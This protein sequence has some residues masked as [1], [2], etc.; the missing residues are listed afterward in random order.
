[1]CHL[2]GLTPASRPR[3]A[4]IPAP[5]SQRP[6]ARIVGLG[7]QS[8]SNWPSSDAPERVLGEPVVVRFGLELFVGST[9]SP[10]SANEFCIT[11]PRSPSS[12]HPL[13]TN[14]RSR[15]E[16]LAGLCTTACRLE[17]RLADQPDKSCKSGVRRFA[18]AAEV[19][20]TAL[21]T[22]GSPSRSRSSQRSFGS[23]LWLRD[24]AKGRER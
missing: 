22:G 2:A 1:V 10:P 6:T 20:P 18:P 8:A 3:P 17:I 16:R 23:A 7:N 11:S 14:P 19:R 5:R 12:C 15:T 24:C 4:R 13:P 21:G 9:L